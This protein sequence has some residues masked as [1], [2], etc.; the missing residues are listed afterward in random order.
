MGGFTVHLIIII[1]M[2]FV[3]T[4]LS[5]LYILITIRMLCTFPCNNYFVQAKTMLKPEDSFHYVISE[6]ASRCLKWPTMPCSAVQCPAVA[7][8]ASQLLIIARRIGQCYNNGI[9]MPA[10]DI[11]F[12]R[13]PICIG[14]D[15]NHCYAAAILQ[16]PTS[17]T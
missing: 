17:V 2:I 8:N 4:L 3:Y 16:W 10:A 12:S 5:R 9:F 15:D 1:I 6:N 7:N 13:Y 11:T 14:A